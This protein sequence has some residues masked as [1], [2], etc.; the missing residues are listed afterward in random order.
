[1]N[2][3]G[4]LVQH[5]DYRRL[6]TQTGRIDGTLRVSQLPRVAAEMARQPRDEDTV[7]VDLV[8]CEDAQRRVRVEGRITTT[9]A[10]CCQRCLRV[11]PQPVTVQAA[12]VV[13]RD[14]DAAA[15]VPRDD[16]PIEAQG[17]WLDVYALVSDELLLAL[18]VV[19]RCDR[20]DCSAGYENDPV[21]DE[22]RAGKRTDNP[23]AVLNEIKRDD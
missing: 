20:N 10:L 4:T 12:G 3:P 8:F 15:N 13:A 18:P 17:D 6:A 21:L 19:A 23:F 9:L 14:D 22:P 11:Y 2:E 5:V 7:D 16:E 1:M